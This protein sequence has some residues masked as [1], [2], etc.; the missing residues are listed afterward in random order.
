MNVPSHD[1]YFSAVETN[2]DTFTWYLDVFPLTEDSVDIVCDNI[3]SGCCSLEYCNRSI[4]NQIKYFINK[5]N[6]KMYEFIK[7]SSVAT[8]AV[9]QGY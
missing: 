9:S 7:Q 2:N 8:G 3:T 4:K 6:I 5:D 1:T